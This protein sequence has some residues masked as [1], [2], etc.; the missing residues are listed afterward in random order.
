MFREGR[1]RGGRT[2]TARHHQRGKPVIARD[3]L[4]ISHDRAKTRVSPA[5]EKGISRRA[6]EAQ[7]GAEKEQRGF[8]AETRRPRF[9]TQVFP[10]RSSAPRRLCAKC[11]SDLLRG[12]GEEYLHTVTKTPPPTP[13]PE[14]ERGRNPALPPLRFGEGGWGEGFLK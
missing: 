13:L 6:A 8:S 1:G 9:P 3:R 11:L 7:R 5:Q 2:R 12:G 4:I 14:T 10:L